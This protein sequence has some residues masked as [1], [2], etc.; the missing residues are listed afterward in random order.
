LHF[1]APSAAKSDYDPLLMSAA[2]LV[3]LSI[4]QDERVR[5]ELALVVAPGT[6]A[7]D[8]NRAIDAALSEALTELGK[9]L[10][11][12]LAAPPHRFARVLPGKDPEGRMRF[13]IRGCAEGERLVPDHGVV[14]TA[15]RYPKRRG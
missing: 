12:V 3:T 11:V 13:S 15:P 14:V 7:G 4:H 9:Q 1:F 10:G 6:P 5:G 2:P 8:S